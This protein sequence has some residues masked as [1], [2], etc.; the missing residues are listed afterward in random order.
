MA[1]DDQSVAEGEEVID[2]CA[3]VVRQGRLHPTWYDVPSSC[4]S[5]YKWLC[6][7]GSPAAVCRTNCS[8]LRCLQEPAI[9]RPATS[10]EAKAGTVVPDAEKRW[11][12]R[13][14]KTSRFPLDWPNW[15]NRFCQICILTGSNAHATIL[16]GVRLRPR[17]TQDATSSSPS[18]AKTPRRR[19]TADLKAGQSAGT[20]TQHRRQRGRYCKS[21]GYAKDICESYRASPEVRRSSGRTDQIK[22]SARFS[23]S[24]ESADDVESVCE[25]GVCETTGQ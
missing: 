19:K 21:L 7:P 18:E 1:A 25:V 17:D 20:H 22:A 6:V 11:C 23:P 10:N 3:S 15:H 13:K 16:Q 24:D 2:V 8:S 14:G 5:S 4:G 9:Y 12:Q